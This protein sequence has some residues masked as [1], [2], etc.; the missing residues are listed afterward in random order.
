MF[1]HNIFF[2]SVFFV[3]CKDNEE[4]LKDG[5]LFPNVVSRGV[6]TQIDLQLNRS[7]LLQDSFF[8]LGK[9]VMIQ[10]AYV[11]DNQHATMDVYIQ[12]NTSMLSLRVTVI[13][14]LDNAIPPP[15]AIK[16]S[17]PN[18]KVFAPSSVLGMT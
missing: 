4:P 15:A 17:I 7:F 12:P 6:E 8:D 2:V 10:E 11:I 18:I 5:T 1:G 16:L 13:R 14:V 3:S 9:G